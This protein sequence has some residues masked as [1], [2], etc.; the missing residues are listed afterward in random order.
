[1][2]IDC[3]VLREAFL[4]PEPAVVDVGRDDDVAD[5][6]L[7]RRRVAASMAAVCLE[8]EFRRAKQDCVSSRVSLPH[9]PAEHSGVVQFIA[10]GADVA[11]DESLVRTQIAPLEVV[12]HDAPDTRDG[13]ENEDGCKAER[14][15][16]QDV[17]HLEV[18][19]H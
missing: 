16:G 19:D 11:V 14:E 8:L 15:S 2:S 5:G 4:A 6:D 10:V 1:M 3:G 9:E 7:H 13:D 12:V 18:S 17:A